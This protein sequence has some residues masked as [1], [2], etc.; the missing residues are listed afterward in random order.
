MLT[1]TQK[2]YIKQLKDITQRS[3]LMVISIL[4]YFQWDIEKSTDFIINAGEFLS[5]DLIPESRRQIAEKLLQSELQEQDKIKP[6]NTNQIITDVKQI[7]D[8]NSNKETINVQN[9][10]IDQIKENLSIIENIEWETKSIHQDKQLIIQCVQKQNQNDQLEFRKLQSFAG[11]KTCESSGS[12]NCIYQLFF[13][14]PEIVEAIFSMDIQNKED[15]NSNFQNLLQQLFASLILTNDKSV[16]NSELYNVA[17]KLNKSQNYVGQ[18]NFAKQFEIQINILKQFFQDTKQESVSIIVNQ[19]QTFQ[20]H[21]F[22]KLE[23]EYRLFQLSLLKEMN[24]LTQIGQQQNQKQCWVFEISRKYDQDN[25]NENNLDYW[26]PK[27]FD[28]EF[29]LQKDRL[30]QILKILEEKTKEEII[31]E[32][33]KYQQIINAFHIV[34]SVLSEQ[35][36]VQKETIDS[37]YR[38]YENLEKKL[39]EY[40]PFNMEQLEMNS[41]NKRH[42]YC[43]QATVIEQ[44]GENYHLFYLYIKNF[45]QNKWFRINDCQVQSV[46][47]DLVLNDTRKYGCFLVYVKEDQIQKLGEYQSILSE[48]A[49]NILMNQDEQIQNYPLIQKL[50]KSNVRLYEKILKLNQQNEAKLDEELNDEFDQ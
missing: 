26:F 37:L 21:P 5:E 43:I 50:K 9:K 35:D 30:D 39:Y 12:F 2:S 25:Y 31:K 4:I 7:K 10:K 47:E 17:S 14:C 29:L 49:S 46:S 27:K 28:L 34:K 20:S 11:I 48:I 44:K 15:L 42:S 19:F 40:I 23:Q 13:Q 45:S 38:E 3:D 16:N 1:Q 6:I 41:Q 18:I 33:K 24:N 22:L 32:I 8:T 36:F